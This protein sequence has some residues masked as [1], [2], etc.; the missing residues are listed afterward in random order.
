M[1]MTSRT[2]AAARVGSAVLVAMSAA[3]CGSDTPTRGTPALAALSLAID[4]ANGAAVA[5][6]PDSIALVLGHGTFL[7]ARILDASGAPIPGA[8]ATW[9]STNT[10]VAQVTP[11][12]DSGL[13]ADHG[14]AAVTSIASGTALVIA[15]YEQIADTAKV[16]ILPRVDSVATTPSPRARQFDLT[17]R[18]QG[19]LATSATM[20]DSAS[21]HQPLPGAQV[22]LTLLPLRQGDSVATGVT[23]VTSPTVVGTVTTDAQGVARFG[24]VAASRYRIAVQPPSGSSWTGTTSEFGPPYWAQMFNEMWLR[25][26]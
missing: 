12:A 17:V 16:T 15:T 3:A 11:L 13:V 9:R 8:K 26:P 25:R 18:V 21:R 10:A 22:T 2:L 4:N 5:L 19:V 20:P 6:T 1:S 14:R 24:G 23:P 7:Q